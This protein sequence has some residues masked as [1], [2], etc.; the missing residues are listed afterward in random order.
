[1]HKQT[2]LYKIPEKLIYDI[3]TGAELGARS[4]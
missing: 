1:M 3:L 4:G 2:D